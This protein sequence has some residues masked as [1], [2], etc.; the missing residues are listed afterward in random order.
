M[1]RRNKVRLAVSWWKAINDNRWHL[2][3]DEYHE[4]EPN[5]Y[6]AHYNFDAL[7]H[8]FKEASLRECAME[9]YFAKYDLHPLT[10]VYEDFIRDYEGTIARIVEFL[11]IPYTELSI[12][13]KYSRATAT[14]G[15]ERWVQRFRKELQGDTRT[16]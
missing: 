2:N 3:R 14:Q 8:L 12:P 15:S 9:E 1:S 11:G 6:E 16:W 10:V 13:P 7:M 5:F 4:N